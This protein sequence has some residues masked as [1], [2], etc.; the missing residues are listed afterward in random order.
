MKLNVLSLLV[1]AMLYLVSCSGNSDTSSDNAEEPESDNNEQVAEESSGKRYEVESGI[2]VYEMTMM[3]IQSEAKVYFTDYGEKEVTVSKATVEMMGQ[4]I[5]T[6]T[7]SFITDGYSYTLD[8]K[9]KTG[10]KMKVDE[11]INLQ[12]FDIKKLVAAQKEGLKL[13][14]EGTETF[15]GKECKVYT[16][17]DENAKAR[18]LTWKNIALKWEV[19]DVNGNMVFAAKSIEETDDIPAGLF[20]IP[21]DYTIQEVSMDNMPGM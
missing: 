6:E 14:E 2:V 15:L 19:E 12:H 1:A 13:T 8:V 4:K 17:E 3:G 16:I 20:D 9:D 11:D 7:R 21:A 18:Y 10:T 5:E